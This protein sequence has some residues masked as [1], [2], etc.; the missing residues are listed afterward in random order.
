MNGRTIVSVVGM[1]AIGA[2]CF[3]YMFH[4][5][6]R[7]GIAEDMNTATIELPDT[8]GLVVGARVLLRGVQIGEITDITASAGTVDVGW[9]YDRSHPIA[10]GSAFR[11]DN[12][13]ALGEP[14]L[15]VWPTAPGGPYIEDAAVIESD[16]VVTSTTFEELS[17]RLT[18]LLT[19]VEPQAVQDIFQTL[20]IALPDDPRVYGNIKRAGEKLATT[21]TQHADSLTTVL[22]TLQPLL[23]ESGPVPQAIRD[24]APTLAEFGSDF[25]VF[26]GSI[27][28]AAD[29]GPLA[30]GIADGV[31]PF[32]RE[33]QSFLDTTAPDLQTIG[34]NLLPAMSEAS[35][36]IRSVDLGRLLE[37][38]LVSTESGD[39]LTV[40]V[41]NDEK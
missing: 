3:G 5:G 38:V 13:S 12:L 26:I 9:K 28:F 19:Q 24:A 4:A 1:V 31:S 2:L 25:Q 17:Q 35:N 33:L 6:L 20:D 39:A 8:N 22:R 11:V 27:K 30:I 18:V 36:S 14:V 40:R 7:T 21:L 32:L 37:N 15:G 29:R 23:Q 34:V 10:V 41:V 16:R